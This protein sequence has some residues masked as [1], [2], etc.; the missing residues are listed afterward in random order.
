MRLTLLAAAILA[1]LTMTACGKPNQAL[2]E[3]EKK[4]FEKITSKPAPADDAAPGTTN[5]SSNVD[6]AQDK[7]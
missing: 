2:P 1:A 4:N 6:D 5:P 7:K 3:Q